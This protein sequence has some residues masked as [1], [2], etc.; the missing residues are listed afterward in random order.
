MID[1]FQ[2]VTE[3]AFR[4]VSFFLVP[5]TGKEKV[6]V[7]FRH[8]PIS[9]KLLEKLDQNLYKTHAARCGENLYSIKNKFDNIS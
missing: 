5:Y 1:L 4:F 9:H 6:S 8:C 7:C 3:T 2:K